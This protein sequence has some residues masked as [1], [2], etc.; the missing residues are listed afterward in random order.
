MV[1]LA[2]VGCG[3]SAARYSSAALRLRGAA[4]SA[5]VDPD[6]ARAQRVARSL[7]A[8]FHASSLDELLAQHGDAFDAVVIGSANDTHGPLTE[9]AAGAG[10]HVFVEAPP[11]L[12]ADAAVA[13]AGACEAGGVR[14]MVGRLLR[15]LPAHQA[16]RASLDAGELGAP[17]LLRVHRWQPR[18]TGD[19]DRWELDPGRSGGVVVHQAVREIDLANWV[20]GGLPTEVYAL[21][22]KRADPELAAPDYV[23]IHLGFVDGGMA[24]IDYA[25]TLPPGEGYFYLE[26]M[27]A[28]G[29]AFADDHHNMQLLYHG[30]HPSA[31]RTGQADG[32]VAAELQEFVNAILEDREP[33]VAGAEGQAALRVAEA[34]A[35][36]MAAGRAA[37]PAGGRYELV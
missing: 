18:P 8:P 26:L 9:R 32:A 29:A 24:L 20:F 7:D 31:L 1:R 28:T 2:L 23:H 10:K 19:R 30:G 6:L 12:T 27:G 13:A 5:T 14:L 15:H 36:S 4:F 21:G 34:V 22:R 3:D 37:R 35:E 17:G 16:I 25:M 33:A 11:A